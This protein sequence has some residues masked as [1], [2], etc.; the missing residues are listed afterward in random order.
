MTINNAEEDSV[1]H[2]HIEAKAQGA[3]VTID[4]QD[5]GDVLAGYTL[6]HEVGRLPELILQMNTGPTGSGF[7]GMARVGVGVPP[8]PGPAAAAFLGAIDAG[9]LEKAALGRHDLDGGPHA[10]TR[11]CLPSYRTGRAGSTDRKR[12]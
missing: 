9:E 8:D 11:Q 3:V 6:H 2:V 10:L 7:E 4:G 1:R 5:Y 12:T